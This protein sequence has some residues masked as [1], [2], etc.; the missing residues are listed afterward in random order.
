MPRDRARVAR[1]REPV[2]AEPVVRRHGVGRGWHGRAVGRHRRAARRRHRRRDGRRRSGPAPE[3]RGGRRTPEDR[4]EPDAHVQVRGRR[5]RGDRTAF[6][7]G[8]RDRQPREDGVRVRQPRP[9]FGQPVLEHGHRRRCAKGPLG[10]R[11]RRQ[12]L[13]QA[14]RGRRLRRD[15]QPHFGHRLRSRRTRNILGVGDLQ[16]RRCVQ[17]HRQRDDLQAGRQ[18]H[19][20]RLGQH[21]LQRSRIERRCSRGFTRRTARSGNRPTPASRG[22][23]LTTLP[24]AAG[25]CTATQVLGATNLSVGCNNGGVFHSTDGNTWTNVGA[26]GVIPQPLVASD[27][28]IY[29]PGNGGGLVRSINGGATFTQVAD[30]NLAARRGRFDYPAELPD[31]RIVV[32]G[33]DHL[34][35]SADKGMTWKPIGAPFPTRRR[36]ATTAREARPIRRGPRRFTSGAGTARTQCR[37]MRS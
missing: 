27:G 12:E 7:V 37:P 8:Q 3:D 9:G 21:R 25:Y 19:P 14:R 29:W 33:K 26:K 11:G 28:T 16:R 22:P 24:G 18:H 13:G 34:Q 15:H 32:V 23:T 30:N 17:D 1:R 5:A 2:Q 31:G 36:A 20:Q 4:A 6:H 35:I 10:N